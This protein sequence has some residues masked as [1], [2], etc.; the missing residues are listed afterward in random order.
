M[1]DPTEGGSGDVPGSREAGPGAAVV[2][3]IPGAN[4]LVVLAQEFLATESE[5]PD[6]P[7]EWMLENHC[8]P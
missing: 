5:H 2:S 8:D 1:E 4:R 6:P 3:L 7:R